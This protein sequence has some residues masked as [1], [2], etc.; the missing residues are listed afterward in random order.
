M[1][2]LLAMILVA[3]MIL[4]CAFL[5][6][7]SSDDSEESEQ[8]H[9]TL[10][11][12]SNDKDDDQNANEDD[13]NGNSDNS[14]SSNNDNSND[15]ND[16]S[17]DN[18]DNNSGDNNNT[19]EGSN[20]NTDTNPD[21]PRITI[22]SLTDIS[23]FVGGVATIN[24]KANIE[25]PDGKGGYQSPQT[26]HFTFGIDAEGNI[27]HRG[28]LHGFCNGLKMSDNI[29]YNI[30][31]QEVLSP[32]LNGYDEI[33]FD[34]LFSSDDTNPTDTGL[35][36][37]K[38]VEESFYG[39]KTMYGVLNADGQWTVP[40]SE[41]HPILEYQ[42][43]DALYGDDIDYLGNGIYQMQVDIG[44]NYVY[45]DAKT[46]KITSG[47]DHIDHN[48]IELI[49]YKAD[50]TSEVLATNC[51]ASFGN[52]YIL[53]GLSNNHYGLIDYEGN[54]ISDLGIYNG[55]FGKWYYNNGYFLS[56]TINPTGAS[57]C[58]LINP[59]GQPAFDPIRMEN[60]EKYFLTDYGFIYQ[61]DINE[62]YFYDF[63]GNCTKLEK[64]RSIKNEYFTGGLL[65]AEIVV[66]NGNR[67]TIEYCYLNGKGEIA[68]N[69]ETLSSALIE[70]IGS[71]D[72]SN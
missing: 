30:Y 29:V 12:D 41:D 27:L 48:G 9:D 23:A 67:D 31:G 65:V 32:T 46:N 26:R 60:Y 24:V 61:T 38:K 47:Y 14:N 57:Y 2:K 66:S 43:L 37:V 44:Y 4:S 68:I 56:T 50:G 35:F 62:V 34:N 53:V 64:V 18:D 63:E 40:L 72:L 6:S 36:L 45:Y 16:N 71:E 15:N 59:D 22:I 1:K 58:I 19:D 10:V 25:F 42:K 7:C 13:N 28:Y 49:W 51:S 52:N 3:T 69:A 5:V 20:D 17:N 21:A 55:F 54:I 33:V 11:D 39:D 8:E 70:I